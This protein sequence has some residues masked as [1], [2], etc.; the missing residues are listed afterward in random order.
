MHGRT[1]EY[2][3]SMAN[4]KSM[5]CSTCSR[6][7]ISII[8]DKEHGISLLN[9]TAGPSTEMPRPSDFYA[10]NDGD[11]KNNKTDLIFLCVWGKLAIYNISYMY[12]D[13]LDPRFLPKMGKRLGSGL[14]STACAYISWE[15]KICYLRYSHTPREAR[16]WGWPLHIFPKPDHETG[17]ADLLI[18]RIL[19]I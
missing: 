5:I 17:R 18:S 19:N 8:Q 15:I 4:K 9:W 2:L 10:D 16:T 1:Q 7:F 14:V 11:Q 6:S 12:R 3:I 13:G